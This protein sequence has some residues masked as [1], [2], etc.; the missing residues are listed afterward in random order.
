MRIAQTEGSQLTIQFHYSYSH[1]TAQLKKQLK[2]GRN[3]LKS[4]IFFK[5]I[6]LKLTI[7]DFNKLFLLILDGFFEFI[8]IQ[9]T[10]AILFF[11]TKKKIINLHCLYHR[12]NIFI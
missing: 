2:F 11:V 3:M 8:N 7:F 10:F 12:K 5:E 6:S 9:Y 4:F 1:F